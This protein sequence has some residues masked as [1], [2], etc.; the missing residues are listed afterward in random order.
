MTSWQEGPAQ[1]VPAVTTETVEWCAPAVLRLAWCETFSHR[2]DPSEPARFFIVSSFSMLR[3]NSVSKFLLWANFLSKFLLEANLIFVSFFLTVSK[4]SSLQAI[5]VYIEIVSC[6]HTWIVSRMKGNSWFSVSKIDSPWAN[7]ILPEQIWFSVSK[8]DSPWANLLSKFLLPINLLIVS[9]F[10]EQ[11]F[12][13]SNFRGLWAIFCR[14]QQKDNCAGRSSFEPAR[15][16]AGNGF[17]SSRRVYSFIHDLPCIAGP[18][19][20]RVGKCRSDCVGIYGC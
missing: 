5:Y 10:R 7:L 4:F 9:K 3:A 1:H 2:V 12:S 18:S 20:V 16:E 14:R 17:S 15:H 8:F 13:L 11:F 19:R 6:V